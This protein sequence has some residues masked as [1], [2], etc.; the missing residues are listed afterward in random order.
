MAVG[1]K[2]SEIGMENSIILSPD[3][4][5]EA[6]ERQCIRYHHDFIP[7]LTER[8]KVFFTEIWKFGEANCVWVRQ[9]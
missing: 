4:E 9:C 1:V 7:V 2:R 8:I 6:V 3:V 5:K